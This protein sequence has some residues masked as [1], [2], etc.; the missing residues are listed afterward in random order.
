MKESK[1]YTIEPQITIKDEQDLVEE[2][3][4][5]LTKF[6]VNHP[7]L[8]NSLV[9]LDRDRGRNWTEKVAYEIGKSMGLPIAR[10]EL[11]VLSEEFG[12]DSGSKGIITPNYQEKDISYKASEHVIFQYR[13]KPSYTFDDDTKFI[14]DEKIGI[15]PNYQPP[16]KN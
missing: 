14:I 15:P 7:E 13:G 9:K 5:Y 3:K 10:Y 6:W 4:G 16:K 11:A 8:G 1:V 2:T 12:K